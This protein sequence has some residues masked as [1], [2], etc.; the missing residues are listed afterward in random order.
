[1]IYIP[2]PNPLQYPHPENIKRGDILSTSLITLLGKKDP[3]Q[4]VNHPQ[5]SPCTSNGPIR[6]RMLHILNIRNFSPF[7]LIVFFSSLFSSPSSGCHHLPSREKG[8]G[9]SNPKAADARGRVESMALLS[10]PT[11]SDGKVLKNDYFSNWVICVR[12]VGIGFQNGVKKN[13]KKIF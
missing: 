1:M 8:G 2:T 7:F 10:T 6:I 4:A 3:I 12:L 11:V 9:D 13:R 5:R